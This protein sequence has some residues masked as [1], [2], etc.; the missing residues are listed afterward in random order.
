MAAMEKLEITIGH[1]FEYE[2]DIDYDIFG[3]DK[4]DPTIPFIVRDING[5]NFISFEFN[6]GLTTMKFDDDEGSKLILSIYETD[7]FPEGLYTYEYNPETFSGKKVASISGEMIV[8]YKK[9]DTLP[10]KN[11]EVRPWDL[12][13]SK[14]SPEGERAPEEKQKE[15]LSICQECPRFV[16]MTSQCL[17]CGC[18]MKL[19]TK[20]EAATC[21]LGKW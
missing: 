14:N 13:R 12:L 11:R 8:S 16:K 18:I 20:L 5:E 17:E 6:Y 9:S 1:P 3:E 21:P 10:R 4:L 2:W 7:M 19:K 15:R